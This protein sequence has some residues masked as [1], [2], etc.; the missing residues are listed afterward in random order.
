[1]IPTPIRVAATLLLILGAGCSR[2]AIDGEVSDARGNPLPG[3]TVAAI[4]S[5]CLTTVDATGKFALPCPPGDYTVV[6]SVEGYTSV[7]VDVQAP[8]RKRYDIGK[9]VL[10][11]VP[12]EKGLFLFG[13]DAYEPMLPG[14]V[15]RE[16]TKDGSLTQRKFCLD[17]ETS[18]PNEVKAGV[19]SFFDYEHP[20]WRPFRL[21]EEGCAY[22]DTKNQNHQWKVVYRE[23]AEYETHQVN[24]GKTIARIQL[25]PGQYFIADWKGFFVPVEEHDENHVY[26]G[27]WLVV[28]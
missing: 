9:Q 12:A 4:G 15:A 10:I 27:N 28:K 20:G 23:K 22:R 1:M 24:E 13:S 26:T 6:I 5:P 25:E 16:L 17:A 21:D 11:K 7:Q 14:F 3:A 2:M 8:E 18:K 19:A